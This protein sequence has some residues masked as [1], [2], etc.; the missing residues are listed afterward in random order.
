[1]KDSWPLLVAVLIWAMPPTGQAQLSYMTNDGTI[2]ITGYSGGGAVAIPSNING[3]T[4]TGIAEDAFSGSS[5]TSVGIPGTVTTI[6][7]GA[8]AYSALTCITIPGSVI[9]IGS[10]VFTECTGLTN[11]TL[12]LGVPGIAADMFA[13]CEMLAGI[14]IPGS[15][16]SIGP[17]AFESCGSLAT[18][19]IPGSVAR[20]QDDAFEDCTSLSSIFFKGKAP[21]ADASVFSSDL[22]AT[23][24]YLPG[25]T[26]WSN[27]FA[28]L[29]AVL[30]NP[31]IQTGGASFGV[32][33]NQFGFN[34]AGTANIPLV[35]EASADLAAPAWVPL[36]TL[37]LT[38]GL[39]YFSDSQ[40]TN[41][42]ERFY[43]IRS[44]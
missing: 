44:P 13:S 31:L 20:I 11:A 16:G 43:R 10:D 42:A 24:Y 36:A 14:S 1:M 22:S 12:A 17:Y 3:L 2:V 30:W 35:V 34:I 37:T 8:F 41:D 9:D 33:S 23:V 19:T 21:M 27:T 38:N 25:N 29:P 4:V 32:L 28:G 18:I 15:V 5:V 6:G 7:Q 40:W 26:G 39:V